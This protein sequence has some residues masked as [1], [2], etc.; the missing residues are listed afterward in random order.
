MKEPDVKKIK[1]YLSD[2]SPNVENS[3]NLLLDYWMNIIREE[4]DD[5]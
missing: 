3:P 2:Y 1:E 4:L 5:K